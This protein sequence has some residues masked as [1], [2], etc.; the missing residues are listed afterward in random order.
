MKKEALF[1]YAQ[2]WAAGITKHTTALQLIRYPASSLNSHLGNAR[3]TELVFQ[4]SRSLS[5]AMSNALI[6][7]R[8]TAVLYIEKVRTNLK[9]YLGER[10]STA[11][12]Q[13]GFDKGTL[14]I[15]ATN[16][17]AV[18]NIVRTLQSYLLAHTAQQNAT[19][20]VTA[21]AAGTLI[22]TLDTDTAALNDAKS[23]QRTKREGRDSTHKALSEYLRDSRR[24]V[25]SAMK[26]DDARW[27]DFVEMVPGDLRAPEA[28][29]VIVAEPGLPGHVRLS[30]LPS[31]RAE[32]YGVYVSYGE[33][34][35]FLHLT[36]VH[37]TVADL[38]LTP[39]AMVRV[40]VKASNATGQSAPSPVA[41]VTVPMAAA[42]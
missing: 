28:V 9:S 12:N 1:A 16:T 32:A 6:A 25:E 27:K 18:V 40:R 24:E 39:G 37:D 19:N 23:Q 11:W 14:Q 33:G 29:S 4:T 30:F 35:P 41:T 3:Q 20:G 34:Q 15:P 21:A 42:A 31:L 38:V 36:T 7:S 5:L 8:A 26:D 17:A 13:A 2:Q 10:W 22:T